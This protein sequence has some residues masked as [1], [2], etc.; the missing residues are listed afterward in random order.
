MNFRK[1]ALLSAKIASDKKGKDIVILDLRKIT[2]L[3]DYFVIV[4]VNS[5]VHM[6]AL[7][8][9][10]VKFLKEAGWVA[11]HNEMDDFWSVIDYS[12]VIIHI[13]QP[14]TRAFYGLERIWSV[15]KCV[16]FTAKT[17]P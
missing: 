7:Y 16:T 2:T 17:Q 1:L 10:I 3:C 13:M 8:N 6:K 4:S 11:L 15:A 9:D 14:Q 5:A 12:G